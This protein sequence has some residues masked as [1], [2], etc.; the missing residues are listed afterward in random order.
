MADARL[1]QR[2]ARRLAWQQQANDP[3]AEPRNRLPTLSLLRAWQ[4]ARLERDFADF[5]ADPRMRPAARFFLSDLYGDKDFSARDRDAARILPAMARLLPASL[6]QAAAQAIELAVLSH[7]FDLAMAEALARRPRPTAPITLEDYGRAYR[8]VAC[9]RLRRH[10][11]GLILKVG[12]TLDAAVQKHGVHRL[13]RAARVPARLAGLSELQAFLER[14]FT[15]FEALGGAS[16]F[17]EAIGAREFEASRRLM[18]GDPDPFGP[19]SRTPRRGSGGS[20]A[21]SGP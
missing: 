15:A 17:L 11:I 10:Q 3:V 8:E 18:A 6:L 14:G 12:Y 1:R 5:L 7:A 13:L 19:V 4:A 16:D 21:R 20:R 2:L 9:P